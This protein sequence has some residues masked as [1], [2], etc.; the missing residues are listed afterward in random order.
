MSVRVAKLKLEFRLALAV[1]LCSAELP[2]RAPNCRLTRSAASLSIRVDHCAQCHAT[3]EQGRSTAT[4][5]RGFTH[6]GRPLCTQTHASLKVPAGIGARCGA[7]RLSLPNPGIVSARAI[8]HNADPASAQL[9]TTGTS[10][11]TKSLN[12]P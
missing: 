1:T 4:R 5:F 9:E 3:V 10:P 12:P 6:C 2:L 8:R 11:I 7:A